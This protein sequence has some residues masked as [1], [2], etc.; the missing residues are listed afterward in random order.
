MPSA[1]RGKSYFTTEILDVDGDG[2]SDIVIGG[3]E[4]ESN[5]RTRVLLNPGNNA[6]S[7]VTPIDLPAVEGYGV[8]LDYVLT[9]SGTDRMLWLLRAGGDSSGS[10]FYVGTAIQRIRWSD[11]SSSTLLA[12]RTLGWSPMFLPTTVGDVPVITTPQLPA[13]FSLAY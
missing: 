6:F 10:N 5:N 3:H 12:D 11:R 4:W 8:V 7:G 9:G 2:R 13:P 1:L